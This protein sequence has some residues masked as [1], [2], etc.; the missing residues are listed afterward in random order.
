MFFV[1]WLVDTADRDRAVLE[2]TWDYPTEGP[3]DDPDAEAVLRENGGIDLKTGQE[4]PDYLPLKDDGSTACG[5][6]IYAGCYAGGVNQVARRKPGAQ[7]SSVAPEWGWAWPMNRRILYNRAS[8]DP[9]GRPWSERKRYLW[10]DA[11]QGKWTGE[12][13]PDFKADMAPDYRPPEDAHGPD[14]L[15]GDEPFT[16]QADGKAWLYAPAGLVDGPMPTHYEPHESPF[17]NPLYADAAVQPGAPADPPRREPV[18]PDARRARGRCVPV[19]GDDLP[20]HRAPHGGRDVALAAPPGRAAARDVLR[21]LAGPG[22]RARP[23]ARELDDG[24]H[25]ARRDR[26]ARDGHRAH[27]AADRR[28]SPGPPGRPALPLGLARHRHRRLGQRPPRPRPRPQR[29]H[30]RV[31]GPDCDVRAGRRPRG[32]ALVAL[33]DDYRRRATAAG[34]S[35]PPEQEERP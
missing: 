12:D 9:E 23:R 35:E 24:H 4:I 32:P 1:S 8:A 11:E 17:A 31:Q 22:A 21:G 13:V 27:R 19:R 3:N 30:R 5:C 33:L 6:W 18:Q 7:Q 28:R 26:G 15:R 10:W 29:P 25:P 14:G 16:M 20:A 2:L 34:V